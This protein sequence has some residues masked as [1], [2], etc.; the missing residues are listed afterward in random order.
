VIIYNGYK[1]KLNY[2]LTKFAIDVV[3]V[4]VVQC[5]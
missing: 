3:Q 5:F 2:Y 4:D 1:I